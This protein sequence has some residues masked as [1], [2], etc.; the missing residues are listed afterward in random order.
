MEDAHYLAVIVTA[1][2][3]RTLV[4]V[5]AEQTIYISLLL[6]WTLPYMPLLV[7]TLPE[8]LLLVRALP[9]ILMLV[10]VPPFIM[11]LDRRC[12]LSS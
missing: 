6:V 1:D 11:L 3:K 9:F 12:P 4:R 5:T 10:W 7:W 8:M 2:I